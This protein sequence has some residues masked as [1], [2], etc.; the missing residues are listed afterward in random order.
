M[1][2]YK[3]KI[4]T[5]LLTLIVLTPILCCMFFVAQQLYIQHEM[6]EKEEGELISL[7]IPLNKIHWTRTNKEISVDG[8]LMDVKSFTIKGNKAFVQG[9]FDNDEDEL[10]DKFTSNIKEKN[11]S[12]LFS[13]SFFKIIF[14]PFYSLSVSQ[15][16]N[17]NVNFVDCVNQQFRVNN[18]HV[19][20]RLLDI[21]SPPPKCS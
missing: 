6:D 4:F 16:T 2:F 14:L 7:T 9:Y 17:N 20:S 5:A 8:K 21:A 10:V 12:S 13:D 11:S 3:S 19:I 15:T 1:T 18:T